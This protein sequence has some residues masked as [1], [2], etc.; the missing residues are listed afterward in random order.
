MTRKPTFQVGDEVGALIGTP[1]RR[2]F[3][4]RHWAPYDQY[5]VR[6]TDGTE[7][8]LWARDL[9]L[10]PSATDWVNVQGEPVNIQGQPVHPTRRSPIK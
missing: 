8:N 6:W 5:R 3:I 7:T 2:G 4:T 9:A 10:V 1:R